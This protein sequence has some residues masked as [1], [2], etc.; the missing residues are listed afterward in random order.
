VWRVLTM[1]ARNFGTNDLEPAGLQALTC[2]PSA[3]WER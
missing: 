1:R 2:I 3:A